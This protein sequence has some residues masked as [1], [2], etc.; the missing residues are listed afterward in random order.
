MTNQA[1]SHVLSIAALAFA[2]FFF[3]PAAL[4]ACEIDVEVGDALAYNKDVIE[5]DGD[6]EQVTINLTHTGQLPAQAMGHNWVLSASSDFKDIANAGMSAG[7]EQ[8]YLPSDDDR[9]IAAT[10]IVGGGE[11]TSVTFSLDQVD[12]DGSYT[13]FCSF[14]GHW[15]VM[16]GTFLVK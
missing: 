12:P 15:S 16:N 2:A 3:S 14:P 5:V 11:S 8:N 4:A 1:V 13:F 9:I 7:L 6:C 10:D